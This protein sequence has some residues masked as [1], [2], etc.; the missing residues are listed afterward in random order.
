MIDYTKLSIFFFF[1]FPLDFDTDTH[2]SDYWTSTY[3]P[4]TVSNLLNQNLTLIIIKIEKKESQK[5]VVQER[6]R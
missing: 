1:F 4:H 3:L 6:I 5:S 2:R